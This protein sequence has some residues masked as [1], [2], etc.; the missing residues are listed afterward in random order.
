MLCLRVHEYLQYAMLSYKKA[1][2]N[3]NGNVVCS[4]KQTNNTLFSFL[5]AD[6]FVFHHL[7][8]S[9]LSIKVYSDKFAES[10]SKRYASR[11]F[12]LQSNNRMDA[13]SSDGC[14]QHTGSNKFPCSIFS[15]SIHILVLLVRILSSV[16]SF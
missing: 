13:W 5:R 11:L 14:I 9:N 7:V 1:I 3:L 12:Q 2:S 16:Y 4:K 6:L 8:L 15:Q 10:V